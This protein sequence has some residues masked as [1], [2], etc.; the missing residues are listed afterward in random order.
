MSKTATVS[1]T[2]RRRVAG[3]A[4]GSFIEFYGFLVYA[5]SAPILAMHFFPSSTPFALLGTFAIFA[6]AFL[7]GPLG[8]IFF[9]YLGDRIGRVRTL[10][11]TILLMGA[12]T[13]TIG[14]LPTYDSIG[15]LAVSAPHLFLP[16]GGR[17]L[18]ISWK[19]GAP[20]RVIAT[21][22][23]KDGTVVRTLAVGRFPLGDKSVVWNGLDRAGKRVKGGV[24]RAHLVALSAF[25][26]VDLVKTF[27]V[28]QIVG[29]PKGS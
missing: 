15:F 21:V 16:P 7:F 28:R 1:S 2:F 5:L 17:D 24:Y 19:M 3:S 22:E 4:V 13:L 26:K 9:G 23:T 6:V 29:P 12:A 25:G 18:A 10:S 8:G 14:L 27:T 11:A 20:A